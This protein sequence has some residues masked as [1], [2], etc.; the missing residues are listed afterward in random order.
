[1]YAS[2]ACVDLCVHVGTANCP[3]YREWISDTFLT[4]ETT[5]LPSIHR[6]PSYQE[7]SFNDVYTNWYDW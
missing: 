1:V 5:G 7:N 6:C 3:P 4:P 2:R